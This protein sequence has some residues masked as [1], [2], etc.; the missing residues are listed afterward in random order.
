MKIALCFSGEARSFQKGFEYYNI[1]VKNS[2]LQFYGD[3]F[4]SGTWQTVSHTGRIIN[5]SLIFND[6]EERNNDMLINAD[7]IIAIFRNIAPTT[8]NEVHINTCDCYSF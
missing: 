3:I 1:K 6:N 8:I 4:Y 7:A 5:I 2:N